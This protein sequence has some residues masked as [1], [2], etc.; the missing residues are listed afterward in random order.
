[1]KR[2]YK[3]LLIILG[4]VVIGIIIAVIAIN[5]LQGDL[6][7]KMSEITIT[8]V[9]LAKV[10]D[11]TYDGSFKIFPVAAEVK[12]TVE[13]HKIT[14]IELVRHENGQGK[15]AEVLPDKVVEAQSLKVDIV[16][17]A[18]YSSKVILKAINNAL[19]STVK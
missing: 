11:G 7:K 6:D 12:V 15:P 13:N 18:T 19:E 16:S 5:K 10:P 2:K 8:D 4:V 14:G 1:M 9:D 3:V 17:G